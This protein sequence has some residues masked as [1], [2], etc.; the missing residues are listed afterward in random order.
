MP[1]KKTAVISLQKN[2]ELLTKKKRASRFR[3]GRRGILRF[4][5]PGRKNKK[6]DSLKASTQEEMEQVSGQCDVQKK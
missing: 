3:C 5:L 6:Y 2:E 4:I 1:L